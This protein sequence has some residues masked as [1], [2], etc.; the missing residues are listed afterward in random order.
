MVRSGYG[1]CICHGG[2]GGDGQQPSTRRDAQHQRREVEGGRR[3]AGKEKG[4]AAESG[5]AREG[6]RVWLR[7]TPRRSSTQKHGLICV[8]HT[9]PQC[10]SVTTLVAIPS[11]RLSKRD[12]WAGQ[13]GEEALGGDTVPGQD[14]VETRS[15][16]PAREEARKRLANDS[17]GRGGGLSELALMK[18]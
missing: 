9:C 5:A 3:R 11:M 8:D 6:G 2:R 10:L 17:R 16:E 7:E 1:A 13:A 14:C 15:R 4:T 18:V 12:G